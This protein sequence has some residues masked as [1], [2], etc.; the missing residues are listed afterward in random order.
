MKPY[1]QRRNLFTSSFSQNY[2][3]TAIN[4]ISYFLKN[5]SSAEEID[6]KLW[7][8]DSYFHTI[9]QNF[10]N[11][12]Q[13]IIQERDRER[14]RERKRKEKFKIR[15]KLVKNQ[16]HH[17]EQIIHIVTV[18]RKYKTHNQHSISTLRGQYE[19]VRTE[20]QGKGQPNNLPTR[21]RFSRGIQVSGFQEF[22]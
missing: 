15:R 16:T 7:R 17:K 13:L 20:R 14:V 9:F 11:Q 22:P 19:E 21:S 1:L 5:A 4:L 12:L 10:S 18:R 8:Q 6:V 2:Y 3:S